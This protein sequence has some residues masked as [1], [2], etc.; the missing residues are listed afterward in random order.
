MPKRNGASAAAA[1]RHHHEADRRRSLRDEALPSNHKVQRIVRLAPRGR[2]KLFL[3]QR[4]RSLRGAAAEGRTLEVLFR[5]EER[6][7]NTNS[8][9]ETHVEVHFTIQTIQLHQRGFPQNLP[10]NPGGNIRAA[11]RE[12]NRPK[13]HFLL[14]VLH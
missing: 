1:D 3:E 10:A 2:E 8:E 4:K 9:R 11:F 14:Q 7:K 12:G 5:E 6:A 13:T